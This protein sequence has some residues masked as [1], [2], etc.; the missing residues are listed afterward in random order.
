MERGAVCKIRVISNSKRDCKSAIQD[1]EPTASSIDHKVQASS[2]R[3]LA[4]AAA[5]H[6]THLTQITT[7]RVRCDFARD[8]KQ[9]RHAQL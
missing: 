3:P 7:R 9:P 4:A 5:H 2:E 8:R 6:D 1:D